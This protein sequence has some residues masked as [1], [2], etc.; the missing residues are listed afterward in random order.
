METSRQTIVEALGETGAINFLFDIL[1]SVQVPVCIGSPGQKADYRNSAGQDLSS[2]VQSGLFGADDGKIE[3]MPDASQT[4]VAHL[5]HSDHQSRTREFAAMRAENE[6]L[7]EALNLMSDG[8]AYYDKD[9]TLL[10][11]ND[12]F[13]NMH[14]TIA[15]I[16]RPG[17]TTREMMIA[18][19]DRGAWDTGGLDRE[20]WMANLQKSRRDGR[21]GETLMQ[22]PDGRQIL[23][24]EVETRDGGLVGIRIDVTKL[25]QREAELERLID[26]VGS[27]SQ[28]VRNAM[29][30]ISA[31]MSDLSARTEHQA[32][33]LEETTAS[34]EELSETVRQNAE[35]A[36]EATRIAS[37]ARE[38]AVTGGDIVQ[39]STDAMGRIEGSAKRIEDIVGLIQEIAFQTNLLA[40][41]AAVEA[42]RAG[43]AGR[44]F[45][46]VANEVRSLAQK[47][48]AASK[49]IK[50]LIAD[51]G[52]HIHDG[53]VLVSEAGT[54]LAQSVASA[55]QVADRMSEIAAASTEQTTGID[56]VSG[57]VSNMDE[58]TQ[59]NA[60]LVEETVAAVETAVSQLD[61]LHRQV[62]ADNTPTLE[63]PELSRPNAASAQMRR[64]YR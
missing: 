49:D 62:G 18:Q 56:Q 61:D 22:T 40:L 2:K 64:S 53:S 45:A 42:A 59:Q 36:K 14:S 27:V 34:M 60:I 8:F 47:A 29:N 39:Q 28:A 6:R 44:G 12:A 24:R 11:Y 41:N 50:Q 4:Q 15:D 38:A 51:S 30:E 37:D 46:V 7:T 19:L 10:I 5:D 31:G 35:N 1:D 52:R 32:S 23:R 17:V 25:K 48:A 21:S 54:V 33:S 58:L 63:Q 43:D 3:S 57:A 55:K 20:T 9:D 26:R 16:I 13:V